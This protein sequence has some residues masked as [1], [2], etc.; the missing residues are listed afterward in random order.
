MST[1]L[2]VKT[3]IELLSRRCEILTSK[4]HTRH[5]VSVL[6]IE[7]PLRCLLSLH[8]WFII[9]TEEFLRVQWLLLHIVSANNTQTQHIIRLLVLW[10]RSFELSLCL[11]SIHADGELSHT[12]MGL[13][14][15]WIVV[16]QL[17]S[18]FLR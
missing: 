15:I 3:I 1:L 12:V 11:V 16:W 6:V 14:I 10:L 7:S 2:R 4:V 9:A 13:P 5:V 8:L 18:V 17:T